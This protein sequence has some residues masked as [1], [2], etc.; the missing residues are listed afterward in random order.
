MYNFET[1]YHY[2]FAASLLI[3]YFLW[4]IG[5]INIFRSDP[6]V[7][8]RGTLYVLIGNVIYVI[9]AYLPDLINLFTPVPE[10]ML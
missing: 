10:W 5:L 2:Y 9:P 4:F 1:I 8:Y 6:C 7:I 3:S